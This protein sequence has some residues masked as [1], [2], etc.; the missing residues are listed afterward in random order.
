MLLFVRD[1]RLLHSLSSSFSPA[2]PHPLP[3]CH[4]TAAIF[5][6]ESPRA[7]QPTPLLSPS[8]TSS[9]L[10]PCPPARCRAW[11]G[12]R[13]RKRESEVGG[14]TLR[15]RAALAPCARTL[16][17]ASMHLPQVVPRIMPCA[18]PQGSDR[19]V[20]QSDRSRSRHISQAQTV[21]PLVPF[22]LVLRTV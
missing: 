19:P 4:C 3:C 22:R 12:R 21:C 1:L 2:H 16:A 11:E 13:L 8:P 20:S 6:C 9:S 17:Q 7:P 5:A 14:G 18:Q 15:K 10:L